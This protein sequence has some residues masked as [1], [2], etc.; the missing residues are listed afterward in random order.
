[1]AHAGC[2]LGSQQIATRSLEE[3]HDGLVFERGRV[4][5]VNY[6]LRPRQRSRQPFTRERVDARVR[7]CSKHFLAAL[8]KNRHELGSDESS[9][10]YHYDLHNAAS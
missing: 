4:R 7:G 6:H 3:L 9:S 1:M 5:K 2:G 10:T 8:A